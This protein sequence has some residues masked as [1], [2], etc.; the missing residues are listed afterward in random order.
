[1]N[2]LPRTLPQWLLTS[3]VVVW[4]TGVLLNWGS[5]VT[6]KPQT[7][8][9]EDALAA[10]QTAIRRAAYDPESASVPAVPGVL[11]NDHY[12]FEWDQSTRMVRLKNR[13]GLDGA[14]TASCAV[15]PNSGRFLHLIV[16]G[17]SVR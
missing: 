9:Q 8:G 16:D 14:V 3:A 4:T 13:L 5:G 17:Q 2:Y 1:M 12:R 15:E 10:C 7:M 11:A 6:T